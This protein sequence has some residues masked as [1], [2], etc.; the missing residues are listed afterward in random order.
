MITDCILKACVDAQ[1]ADLNWCGRWRTP[2][3]YLFTTNI[4]RTLYEKDNSLCVELES[5]VYEAIDE[6]FKGK[7]PNETQSLKNQKHDILLSR[8][9]PNS[10]SRTEAWAILEVKNGWYGFNAAKFRED[11]DRLLRVMGTKG[12]SVKYAF[13]SFYIF[14]AE[15]DSKISASSSVKRK[16]EN[17]IQSLGDHVRGEGY[18]FGYNDSGVLVDD[19]RNA[20]M[21]VVGRISRS[22]KRK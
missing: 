16:S 3:E 17:R 2:P 14:V 4:A 22:T 8:F 12:V 20:W 21:F 9:L 19:A 6:G 18:R 5:D 11:T 7:P 13:M 15:S 10:T 1:E